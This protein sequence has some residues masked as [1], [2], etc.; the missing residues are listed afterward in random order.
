MSLMKKGILS[1]KQRAAARANGR[2]SRGI[3]TAAGRARV[4]DAN[5]RHGLPSQP[6]SGG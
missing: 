2:R 1:E 3:A 4:R 6:A 5:L